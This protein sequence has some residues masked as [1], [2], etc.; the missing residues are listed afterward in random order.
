MIHRVEINYY[1]NVPEY[2]NLKI[3][4]KY[5]DVYM[6]EYNGDFSVSVSNG[7][8]KANSLGKDLNFTIFL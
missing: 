2:L 6:E 8:F 4:N 3:E 1:I 5:G 7:S